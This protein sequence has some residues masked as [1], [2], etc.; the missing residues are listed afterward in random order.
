MSRRKK[1]CKDCNGK[2]AINYGR[3]GHMTCHCQ[4]VTISPLKMAEQQFID[5]AIIARD[6][7]HAKL[8]LRCYRGFNGGYCPWCDEA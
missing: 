2:G 6:A 3:Y 1:V 7:G 8:C 4:R 5:A